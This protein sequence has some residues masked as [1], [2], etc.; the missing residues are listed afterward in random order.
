MSINKHHRLAV[1]P[2][3]AWTDKHCRAFH[4]ILAPKSMLYTEMLTAEA[5]IHGNQNL[6]LTP[7]IIN[8]KPDPLTALQLGGSN[9]S[10]LA[11]ATQIANQYDYA[12]YNLN[13]GCPSDRVQSGRFGACLMAEPNLV[14]ECAAAMI[15]AAKGKAVSVKCRIG[16]DDMDTNKPLDEFISQVSSAGVNHF[17]V[18][19]RKAWLKGLS[20]KE[21]RTLPPLDYDRITRLK[22]DFPHLAISINGGITTPETAL[23][24]SKSFDG[25]MVGRT[26]YQ[27]PYTL[28][29]MSAQIY[30]HATPSRHQIAQAMADYA[31]QEMQKGVP[32]IAITRHMLGLMNGLPGARAW[33]RM[34]SEDARNTNAASSL[35]LTA[36]PA[37][38]EQMAA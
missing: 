4:R 28:A 34:L 37:T 3:M 19:A 1:A 32:L 12:E 16:I 2:M 27:Q 17:I 9:P 25:V 35:I 7:T 14:A 20:P 30:Q 13:I 31:T 11:A 36:I 21:N 23:K 29:E 38:S 6:L 26:A 15:E 18:H 10:H 5:I 22:G 8:G 33:R 24:F